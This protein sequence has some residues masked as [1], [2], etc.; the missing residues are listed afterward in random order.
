[1]N[2]HEKKQLLLVLGLVLAGWG[3]LL[4]FE[5]SYFAAGFY[6][7]PVPF[8]AEW[9]AGLPLWWLDAVDTV[10]VA[11]LIV[12]LVL[13]VHHAH[14]RRSVR[15]TRGSVGGTIVW[16]LVLLVIISLLAYAGFTALGLWS[17]FK[18]FFQGLWLPA[19]TILSSARGGV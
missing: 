2:D 16:I 1:V 6:G 7:V 10:M 17:S 3:I 19:L 13:S 12:A 8:W 18:T 4:F 5:N 14:R 11:V 9:V 15:S